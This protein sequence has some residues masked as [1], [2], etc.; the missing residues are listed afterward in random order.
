MEPQTIRPMDRGLAKGLGWFSI[1]LGLAGLAAPRFVRRLIGLR[2][3]RGASPVV[4]AVGAREIASGV[5]ILS[6]PGRSRPV[7]SRVVGDAIDLALLGWAMRDVCT[8]RGRATAAMGVVAAV[9]AVDVLAAVRLGKAGEEWTTRT[10]TINRMPEEVRR[11]WVAFDD[12]AA[13]ALQYTTFRPAPG[14]RGTEMILK[15]PR[16]I[17]ITEGD[18]RRFKQVIET[19]EIVHSDASIH[20]HMHAAQPPEGVPL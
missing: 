6:M 11:T 8:K 4:R 18:L 13:D 2:D 12:R 10:I 14:G 17:R 3:V 9:T 1:G 7:W 19:G 20:R 15:L 16:H 5:A